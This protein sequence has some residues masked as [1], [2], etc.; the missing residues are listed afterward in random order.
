MECFGS[1]EK[2]S[3]RRGLQMVCDDVRKNRKIQ[4]SFGIEQTWV[5]WRIE[6]SGAEKIALKILFMV[7]M[8]LCF[9]E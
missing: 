5:R 7:N 8:Y 4:T 2:E 6:K 3:L 9:V 1:V